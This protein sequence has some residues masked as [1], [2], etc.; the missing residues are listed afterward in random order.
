MS[1][2][3][4]LVS[5]ALADDRTIIT[6]RVFPF[7]REALFEA[8]ADP[9]QLAL[10]WG[11]R[12]FSNTFSTFDFRPGGDWVL[13]MH[14]PNGAEYP[15]ESEFKEIAKPS[16]IVFEHLRPMHWYRMTVDITD[17]SPGYSRLTWHMQFETAEHLEPIRPFIVAANEQNL[18]R[19]TSV[20][21][22][23]AEPAVYHVTRLIPASREAV[24]E[25]WTRASLLANWWGTHSFTN[26]VCE[27]DA[28]P[29]GELRITMRSPEGVDYPVTG[30]VHE[31]VALE[32]LVF[33]LDLSAYPDAWKDLIQPGRTADEVNPS[34]CLLFTVLFAEAGEQ[35]RLTLTL[36]FDTPALRESFLQHGLAAGW[37][38]GLDSLT[39]LLTKA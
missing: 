35:T 23:R 20:L 14:G 28:S 8:F 37:E 36:R 15:N 33:S 16:R 1:Q 18:D 6:T 38:E 17:E 21:V 19:L 5:P 26:P 10:W 34:G 29:G 2:A 39:A 30:V 4:T 31:V 32:R 13:T 27:I 9:E 7:T 22:Q 24:F 11:P 25:A 3:P 12:G